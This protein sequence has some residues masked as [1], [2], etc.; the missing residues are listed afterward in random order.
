M[1]DRA[2]S[3]DCEALV[4]HPPVLALGIG[5]ERGCPAGEIAD[6]ARASLA[7]A[8]RAAGAVAAIVS[9]ELKAGEPGIQA[10]AAVAR[11]SGAVFPGLASPRRDPAADAALGGRV[12]RDRLLGRGR[13]RRAGRGRRRGRT[14]PAAAQSRH[15]TCAVARAPAPIDAM[16][17]GR[18]RGRLAIIGIGP[19]D[20]AWRTPE[21]SAMIERA[22]D[23]VGY[24]LYLDLLGRTIAGK[25]P[26]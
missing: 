4:L 17:F 21:A 2:V 20:P 10:L 23:I 9:I 14:H 12:S 25:T 6:L 11:R 1:T 18:G 13:G 24:R 26:P 8:G 7:E 5:C 22:D 15:A 16:E 19:G 3:A